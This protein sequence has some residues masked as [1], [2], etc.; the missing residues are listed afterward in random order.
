MKGFRNYFAFAIGTLILLTLFPES[1]W[2]IRLKDLASIRGVRENQ[3]TGYGLVV[4]LNGTGDRPN[5]FTDGSLNMA[6]KGL[7]VDPKSQKLGSKNTAAV[8]VTATLPAFARVGTHVDVHVSSMGSA[9]SIDNGTL[10][11]TALR[12]ADNKV[13]AMAQGRV[14]VS[15]KNEKGM[16]TPVLSASIPQGGLL[17][18]DVAFDF[19]AL[20][21]LRYQLHQPDFTTS[22]RVAHRINEELGGKFATA[23]DA[24]TIDVIL[25]YAMEENPVDWVARL[26]SIDV[27]PDHRAKIVVNRKTGMIVLG[28]DIRIFPVSIAHNNLR[29]LIKDDSTPVAP[30]A[31]G[32]GA[33]PGPKSATTTAQSSPA[34][35]PAPAP[36]PTETTPPTASTLSSTK[37]ARKEEFTNRGAS[38]ADMVLS[39]NEVGASPDDL[40]NLLQALRSSGALV[41]ELEIQ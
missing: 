6:L 17:E 39:L 38:I 26:E 35:N 30:A 1:G 19:S 15:H 33:A 4:G 31:T 14:E 18:R 22:A 28:E 27:E 37:K 13:Y 23:T 34:I 41:A 40:I 25:P 21:D 16:R 7:G 8:L 20:K 36:A 9:T 3:L 32:P 11:I 2:A 10:M 12:G 24:G 29:I 5:D